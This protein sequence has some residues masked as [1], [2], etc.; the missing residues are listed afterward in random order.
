MGLSGRL[1]V[2]TGTHAVNSK[3]DGELA[4]DI[5][6]FLLTRDLSRGHILD[7]N[8]YAPRT[9][10]LLFTYPDLHGLLLSSNAR[11]ELRVI[12]SPSHPAAISNAPAHQFNMIPFEAISLSNGRN[13]DE[14]AEMWKETVK[15]SMI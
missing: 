15:D 6:D 5:F 12:D 8:P 7:F 2:R 11:A 10:P 4:L 3:T 9:E 13:I 1:Y 14:F